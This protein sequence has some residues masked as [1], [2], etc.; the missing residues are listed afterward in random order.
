MSEV[1]SLSGA[2]TE[3]AS[4]RIHANAPGK[5]YIAGEYAVVE[6]GRPAILIAVNR[7]IDVVL[8]PAEGSGLVRSHGNG[9][10]PLYWRHENALP[11]FDDIGS[12]YAANA[13]RT[14]E[15]L[16]SERGLEARHYN[17]DITSGLVEE[18][19]RK[20]GLGSSA[21]VTVAIV[22]VLNRFYHLKLTL[23]ERYKLALL[24]VLERAP[25]ASGGDIAASTY[26]GWVYYRSPDRAGLSEYARSHSVTETLSA[27]AWEPWAV[28]SLPAPAHEELLVGWTGLPASTEHLVSGVQA[29]SRGA[30]FPGFL[31]GYEDVVERLATQLRTGG[32]I[33]A[34]ITAARRLL[35]QLGASSG[36][37][38]ETERL[39]HLCDV[40]AGLGGAAKSSGAGG[41]DCGIAL[42]RSD[43]DKD[44][45]Y[46]GWRAGGVEPLNLAVVEG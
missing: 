34:E 2:D 11:V 18:D 33:G 1:D 3:Q 16:R 14:V 7:F 38:I 13:I 27:P 37:T 25:R 19:G 26:R 20:Y 44:A 22:D 6:A 41:G 23:E 30:Y 10:A 31:D 17:L 4:A 12:D 42:V 43:V 9:F 5:L 8:T 35:R 45:V 15:A 32:R 29:R 39:T 28:E 46:R 36:I 21:A 40:A 24:S